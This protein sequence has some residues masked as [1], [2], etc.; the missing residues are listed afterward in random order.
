MADI[1]ISDMTAGASLTGAEVVPIVQSGANRRTTAQ[2][3]ANLSGLGAVTAHTGTT[4]DGTPKYRELTGNLALTLSTSERNGFFIFKQDATG[5]RTLTING[6]SVAIA[7]AANSYTVVSFTY[8]DVSSTYVI[9]YDTNI[10]GNISGGDSTAPTVVSRTIENADPSTI[11]ITYNEALD[12]GSSPATTAFDIIKNGGTV[13]ASGVVVSGSDVEVGLPTP[14]IS[15]DVFTIA[16]TAPGV[17][18]IQDAAGN[19]ASSYGA[20]AVTNNVS[21]A[22]YDSDADA[23]FTA[24]GITDTTQKNAVNT[25]VLALKSAGVWAK[26]YAIYPFVG[27]DATKHSYNLKN[28]A[29]YQITFNGSWTHDANGITAGG[30]AGDY[31]T[32]GVVPS[33]VF[34]A[35]SAY[36]GVYVRN[37]LTGG[38][39]LAFGAN[40]GSGGYYCK[41]LS[42]PGNYQGRINGGDIEDPT[43]SSQGYLSASRLLAN[44]PDG[45]TYKNGVYFNGNDNAEYRTGQ[46]VYI[47]CMNHNGSEYGNAPYNLAFLMFASGLTDA[48]NTATY[49]AVQTC[50]TSLSRNI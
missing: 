30:A 23:F 44:T 1:K 16:Y 40:D 9:S 15:T 3:I 25:M 12:G 22:G 39:K 24:A 37:N 34:A 31:A 8:N 6:T 33:T 20:A 36:W 49:N 38:E 10:V 21:P 48:E 18:P 28:T 42:T 26:S 43:A 4:W 32:T 46:A 35:D 5:S 2:A 47:G 45:K 50:Q 13:V 7:S 17:N 27:G 29:A 41:P 19:D 11:V 14:A